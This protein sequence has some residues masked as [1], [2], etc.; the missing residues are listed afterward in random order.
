MSVEKLIIS[1]HLET[2]D[3]GV[4]NP[5]HRPGAAVPEKLIYM[6]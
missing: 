2:L 4:A 3:L 6:A 5:F 1:H